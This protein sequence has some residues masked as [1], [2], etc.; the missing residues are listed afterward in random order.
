MLNAVEHEKSFFNLG[1]WYF[2]ASRWYVEQLPNFPLYTFLFVL[3]FPLLPLLPLGGYVLLTFPTG[4]YLL[5]ILT[6]T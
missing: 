6:S 5:D 4:I 2:R 1:A 3:H